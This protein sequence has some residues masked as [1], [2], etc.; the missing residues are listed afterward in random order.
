M[1]STVEARKNDEMDSLKRQSLPSISEVI[2]GTKSYPPPPPTT[3]AQ[4]PSTSFPSPFSSGASRSFTDTEKQPSP[5]SMRSAS[6][7]YPSRHEATSSFTDSPRQ[8]PYSGRPSLPPVPDRRPSPVNKHEIPPPH[9]LSDPHKDARSMNGGYSQQQSLPPSAPPLPYSTSQLPTGQLPLPHYPG[10]P[11]Y[12]P[13]AHNYTSHY[14]QRPPQPLALDDRERGI[15]HQPEYSHF[16]TASYQEALS[17]VSAWPVHAS[18]CHDVPF[19][20]TLVSDGAKL[21]RCL[22]VR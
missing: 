15:R 1:I 13:P 21:S 5:Q 16:D 11:R 8:Q 12:G 3:T 6:S 2:S 9:H 22:W 10:S 18:D 20:L 4:Q 14:D 17:R 19:S 7:A